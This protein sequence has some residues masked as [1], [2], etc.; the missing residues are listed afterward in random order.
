MPAERHLRE[1]VA[2]ALK[3]TKAHRI[4]RTTPFH[5]ILQS[6]EGHLQ[7]LLSLICQ[8]GFGSAELMQTFVAV[9]GVVR[10]R[11][12][13]GPAL[14]EVGQ[15]VLVVVIGTCGHKFW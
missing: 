7:P 13:I 11:G 14:H 8:V 5:A 1:R 3:P 2:V 6:D 15:A 10:R 9:I 12:S 4:T